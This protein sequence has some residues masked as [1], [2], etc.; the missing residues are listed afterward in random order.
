[1]GEDARKHIKSRL[2]VGMLIRYEALEFRPSLQPIGTCFDSASKR[3]V[4]D[5]VIGSAKVF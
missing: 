2:G 5:S 3:A 1:M 4:I